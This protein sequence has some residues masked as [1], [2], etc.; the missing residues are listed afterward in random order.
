VYSTI[1][2]EPKWTHEDRHLKELKFLKGFPTY[3]FD[4]GIVLFQVFGDARDCAAGADADEEVVDLALHLLQDLGA[5]G[6]VMGV[7]VVFV[8]V[9]VDPEA[10]VFLREKSGFGPVTSN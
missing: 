7:R 5:G 10:V 6:F 9:L 4:V 8:V 3:N 2:V 1:R